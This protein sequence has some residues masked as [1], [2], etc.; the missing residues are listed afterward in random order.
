MNAPSIISSRSVGPSVSVRGWIQVIERDAK[1]LCVLDWYRGP[2]RVVTVG[3]DLIAERI[4]GNT[5]AGG[6]S[7]YALGNVGTPPVVGHTALLGEL[8]RA[9]L[10]ATR[11]S[12]GQLIMTSHLGA[13]Q[14]NGMTFEEGGAFTP[15]NT[16]LCRAVFPVKEKTN[17]KELT[18]IHTI[19]L[20]AG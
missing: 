12:A 14:G 19:L 15:E 8:Y 2:N 6:V 20:T 16:M 18:I 7:H 10:T 9:V 11:V 4:R 1:T 3:L 17:L 5:A 13:T